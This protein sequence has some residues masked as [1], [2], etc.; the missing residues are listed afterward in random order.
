[1]IKEKENK[2]KILILGHARSGKD[3]LGELFNEFFGITF[4]S[5]SEKANDL[6]IFDKLKDIH[7]YTSPLE[8]FNDRYDKRTTWYDMIC[9]YNANDRARLAKD[10]LKDADCYVGMRDLEEFDECVNQNL[11]DKIIWVDA[12]KRLP[13]EMGSFNIPMDRADDII[14]N[15]GTEDEF[16]QNVIEFGKTFLN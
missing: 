10:I 8:C 13:D 9:E 7:G 5:S 4:Q 1:M 12:S 16:R 2:P 15:N 6:F 14:D 3:T 11:F